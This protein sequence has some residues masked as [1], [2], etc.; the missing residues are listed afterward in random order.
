MGIVL[1]AVLGWVASPVTGDTSAAGI[2]TQPRIVGGRVAKPGAW[3]WQA[4]ILFDGDASV[5][6]GGSLIA[7]EWILSAAHCFVDDEADDVHATVPRSS[8]RVLLGAQNLIVDEPSQQEFAVAEIIV[9][10]HYDPE[11]SD[12]DIALVKLSG[13]ATVNARVALVALVTAGDEAAVA[14]AG[15][16]AT[17]T[18]WGAT[19]EDG[20]G[21]NVLRQVNLAIASNASCNVAYEGGITANMLCAGGTPL[22]GEDSCQGDSGGPLVVPAGTGRYEQAGIVSFGVGCGEP[23]VPGVYTRVSRYTDWIAGKIA[24]IDAPSGLQTTPD[25]LR[26]LINKPVG[27]EQWAITEN[28]DATVT[29]NIFFTD[30]R[31]PLFLTCTPTSDDGN[32]DPA[33]LMI[34]YTCSMS[35]KCT[36]AQCPGP[37]DWQPIPGDVVLSGSFFLPRVGASAS[38][39]RVAS[40]IVG[41]RDAETAEGADEKPSGLQTTPDGLRNLINKPVGPE[42][43]AITENVEDRTVTGNIFHT[44]GRDPQFIAC[45]RLGDDGNPDPALRTIRY[46]CALSSKCATVEC[47]APN[48]WV[49]LPDEVTLPGSFL[50][51][52]RE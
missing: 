20:D 34:H 29:G 45:D 25:G 32:P 47:P 27:T 24:G 46:R 13:A 48:D 23:D 36:S 44:D 7:P 49:T 6:C 50:L 21:S 22:G 4:A 12:N 18:G 16:V 3:P 10:E 40:A 41:R 5:G 26:T 43:W 33:L 2:P 37:N 52:R 35:A 31:D 14:G 1:L 19:A 38:P 42:Q 9:H 8:V 51:P 17:V 11:T 15:A 30:G 39:R 28:E